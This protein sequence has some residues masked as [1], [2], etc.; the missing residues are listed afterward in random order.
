MSILLIT[1][2]ISVFPVDNDKKCE[3]E[4]I[5]QFTSEYEWCNNIG[6]EYFSGNERDRISFC[7]DYCSNH[8]QKREEEFDMDYAWKIENETLG[9]ENNQRRF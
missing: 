8:L 5:S 3:S 1:Q 2:I 6:G 7:N 9:A 4:L